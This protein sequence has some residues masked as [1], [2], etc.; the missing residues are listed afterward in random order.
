LRDLFHV[1]NEKIKTEERATGNEP[2]FCLR[3]KNSQRFWSG[4]QWADAQNAKPFSNLD[5]AFHVAR[6]VGGSLDLLVLFPAK[7]GQLVIPLEQ[8]N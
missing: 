2:V 8:F 6:H 4:S 1:T 7:T 3:Q 5:S